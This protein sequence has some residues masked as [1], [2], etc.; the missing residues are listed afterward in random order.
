MY[1]LPVD[2]RRQA[3][4]MTCGPLARVKRTSVGSVLVG[5]E[6]AGQDILRGGARTRSRKEEP[7]FA[8]RPSRTLKGYGGWRAR[9]AGRLRAA[10]REPAVAQR[11]GAAAYWRSK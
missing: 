4:D 9:G 1:V 6:S 5:W 10:A 3:G 11:V 7:L 2:M 8:R